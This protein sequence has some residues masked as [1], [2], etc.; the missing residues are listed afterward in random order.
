M[1]ITLKLC[2]H[3][4]SKAAH[5]W[6]SHTAGVRLCNLSC[7]WS[8]WLNM[9][10]LSLFPSSLPLLLQCCHISMIGLH[11][12]LI[13]CLTLRS[14]TSA[15][16]PSKS[17]WLEPDTQFFFFPAALKLSL[18]HQHWSKQ[19]SPLF[20]LWFQ[21]LFA[22]F[23]LIAPH[24]SQLNSPLPLFPGTAW[25]KPEWSMAMRNSMALTRHIVLTDIPS[26]FKLPSSVFLLLDTI[27]FDASFSPLSTVQ[28]QS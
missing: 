17:K 25:I 6:Q 22:S 9:N 21:V 15:T 16:T 14:L 10:Y 3:I 24:L 26:L 12:A 27:L 5:T 23:F 18:Q 13:F 19:E 28:S 7:W 8:V 4:L 11:P 1:V 20:A 2:V